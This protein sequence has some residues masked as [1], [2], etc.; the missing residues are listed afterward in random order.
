MRGWCQVGS[1]H[2]SE[3]RQ[4]PADPAFAFQRGPLL[5]LEDGREQRVFNRGVPEAPAV[6]GLQVAV[7]VAA[8]AGQRGRV[9]RVCV[10]LA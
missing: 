5:G 4:V 3:V 2:P 1:E 7:H 9:V 10:P 6:V 8:K